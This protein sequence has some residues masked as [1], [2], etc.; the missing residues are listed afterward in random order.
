MADF[1]ESNDATEATEAAD[2][3]ELTDEPTVMLNQGSGDRS[4][5]VDAIPVGTRLGKYLFKRL[6]A[7]GGMG[8]VYEGLDTLLERPVA[9][10]VLPNSILKDEIAR[11]RFVREARMAAK[12]NH[13][14]AVTIYDVEI[15]GP[16]HF[17][18]MELV[19]GVSAAVLVKNKGR[20]PFGEATFYAIETCRALQAAHSA[21]LIHRDIK[22]DNILVADKGNVKIADFGLAK[23]T[24]SEQTNLT[25]EDS[26]AVLG[27]P[28]FM[29]PEQCQ[30]DAT[31]AR[32]DIYS[33]GASY[34]KMLTGLAP[35]PRDSLLQTLYAHCNEPAPDPRDKFS[36]LPDLATQIVRKAMAKN[37]EDR[38]Q[39]AD[40][41]LADLEASAKAALI[42]SVNEDVPRQEGLSDA[43]R[44]DTTED[45]TETRRARAAARRHVTVVQCNCNVYE[46]VDILETLNFDE[47]N[48][49]LESFQK[50]CTEI[51][52]E[53][54]GIVVQP[55][56]Q[57]LLVCFGYPMAL[58]DATLR[59]I[60]ASLKICS[61]MDSFNHRLYKNLNVRLA[62]RFAVHSDT[63]IVEDTGEGDTLSLVGPIR[64]VVSQLVNQAE[65][66]T[67]LI[68]DST[69]RLIQGHFDCQSLGSHQLIGIVK[70]I[71]LYRVN[72]Q[73]TVRSRI[74][75][76]SL[77]E[78]TPL[79]GR[80]REVGLLEDRWDQAVEGMGQVVL[81]IGEAG[82]GKSRLV[83]VLS[84]SV[85]SK[86]T[87]NLNP[88]IEWRC[89]AHRRNSS[90]FP[91][92]ECFERILTLD[93][94]D[95]PKMRLDKLTNHLKI[96]D[97][98]GDEET[99]L[100]ASLLSIV[101][102]DDFPHLELSP[103]KQKEATLDLLMRWL[104]QY[105]NLQPVLFIVED[106][107]WIDPSTLQFLEVLIDQG[108]HNRM[109]TLLTFRPEFETPWKSKGHQTQVAL[110]RLT[111]KQVG[112]MMARKSGLKK[113]SKEM[114]DQ[115]VERTDGVP[116]FIEEFTSMILNTKSSERSKGASGSL[117]LPARAIPATLE[118]L[119]MARLDRMA[120]NFELAQ[121]ASAI[122]RE[123]EFELIAA[124]SD[125]DQ[126]QLT[127][128]LSKLVASELLYQQGRP[129]NAR[130][131]FKHALIQD[132]A[133][134]SLI[135]KKRRACHLRIAEAIE[136]KFTDTC[137][138]QPELLAQ[139]FTEASMHAKAIDYWELA[140]NRSLE[141]Y[142]YTEAIEQLTRVL[143]L[144]EKLPDTEENKRR[145]INTLI[146]RIANNGNNRYNSTYN[147]HGHGDDF[148]KKTA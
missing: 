147:A 103:Q 131:Q 28:S 3:P 25:I 102:P 90:L 21:G 26:D 146:S 22:P 100:L 59:A 69:M 107:H 5:S 93:R 99:A 6:I 36:D 82:L 111:K 64:N 94:T 43:R 51:V 63:A 50:L 83:D 143:E 137:K 35:F 96:L 140:G 108:F 23:P 76:T 114:V 105:A 78:L 24:E 75:A 144:L 80:D 47:Q 67:V 10:K 52:R 37:P 126:A 62:S 18:S 65:L 68:S 9:I 101:L 127:V 20:L 42:D 79:I 66:G 125:L 15:Q 73:L 145:E 17:I 86:S 13:P 49:T 129:P 53:Y 54:E 136:G 118:D 41:M 117:A 31:D 34:Y 106:L 88:V 16:T 29:S 71:Q 2:S 61:L 1:F 48:Q 91:V 135:I 89:A 40:L 19:K 134:N 148:C 55:T 33:L 123:F 57:G 46:S 109:L 77:T 14:N 7:R 70:P 122:G 39:S 81:L 112:E 124:V 87:G 132:A 72:S 8:A 60:S 56:D 110:N 92:T 38:Y 44:G 27:T 138:R 30:C 95:S 11:E 120:G 74:K 98:D 4:V 142:A 12:L 113:I 119:L 45:T 130:Y 32:S 128:E 141:K 133:Y 104:H 97:L 58:E 121:L 115:I 139:H 116:L 85:T 84:E